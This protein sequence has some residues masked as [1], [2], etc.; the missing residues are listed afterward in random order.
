MA[1]HCP[2]CGVMVE[3][4]NGTRHNLLLASSW[5]PKTFNGILTDAAMVYLVED[6]A[7]DP[8]ALP[9]YLYL[10]NGTVLQ[11]GEYAIR[12][13]RMVTFYLARQD[14]GTYVLAYQGERE[15]RMTVSRHRAAGFEGPL[16]VKMEGDAGGVKFAA[17]DEFTIDLRPEKRYHISLLRR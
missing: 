13:N 7:G 6:L 10:I 5:G 3:K 1:G 14:D 4:L 17:G 11:H 15:A 9:H 16:Q 8:A 12:L 2:G